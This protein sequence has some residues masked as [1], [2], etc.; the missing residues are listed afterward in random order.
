MFDAVFVSRRRRDHSGVLEGR[1]ET[2]QEGRPG[3]QA[4]RRVGH[5]GG[6]RPQGAAVAYNEA[7][8]LFADGAG[9]LPGHREYLD[10]AHALYRRALKLAYATAPGEPLRSWVAC[11][12]PECSAVDEARAWIRWAERRAVTLGETA[13]VRLLNQLCLRVM[14]TLPHIRYRH[15]D[16]R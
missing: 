5:G 8:G 14:R 11:A 6:L 16:M 2:G 7:G 1:G 10:A 9:V 4:L 12:S 3:G 13:A 15:R